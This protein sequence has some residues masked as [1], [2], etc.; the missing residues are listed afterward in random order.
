MA[1]MFGQKMTA[2]PNLSYLHV[3]S[4]NK[5]NRNRVKLFNLQNL[6]LLK[7]S[8]FHLKDK[9]SDMGLYWLQSKQ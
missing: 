6:V 2:V 3:S 5:H 7:G 9:K 8:T 4:F 1:L